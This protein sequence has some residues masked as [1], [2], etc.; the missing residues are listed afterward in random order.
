MK[1][2]ALLS[3]AS[4]LVVFA[5]TGVLAQ[6]VQ[7]AAPATASAP[8]STAGSDG[9]EPAAGRAAPTK[10]EQDIIVTGSRAASAGYQASTPTNVISGDVLTRQGA[11]NIS[12]VLNQD[13]AFK[14]VQ[15]PGANN[16]K[17]ATPGTATADLRGLG[18]Q[19]TLVLINGMRA[20]PVAPT[21]NTS[22]VATTDLNLIPSLMIDRVEVVTGGASAQWGSDAVAG[23]VNIQLRRKY[24]GLQIK[25]QAGISQYGDNADQRIGA[26][27]GFNFADDKGR[28]VAAVDY[29]N[30][31]GL[32]DIYT[33]DWGRRENQIISNPLR[34]TNGL[35]ALISAPNV[36]SAL[37]AGGLITGPA[38][39]AFRNFTFNP[40]STP[41]PFQLGSLVSGVQMIGGEGESVVKGLSLAPSVERVAS[42]GSLEY[43]LSDAITA[44]LEGSFGWSKGTLRGSLPRVTGLTIQRDNAYL[45]SSIRT[46]MLAAGIT[47]FG[48]QRNGFDIGNSNIQVSNKVPRFTGSLE[49]NLGG[50][51]SWDTNLT[52]GRDYY[53]QV[54]RNAPYAPNLRFALDAVVNPAS[55]QIVCRATIAGAAFNSGASGC[56]PLNFFG[57]GAP[58][59]ASLSYITPTTVS[60]SRY[61][62]QVAT[63]NLKGKPFSTWAGP[64]SIA[65]GFEYRHEKQVVKVDSFGASGGYLGAGNATPFAGSFNIKE[66]YLDTIVPLARD[67]SFAKSIDLNAAIR[68]ADYSTVGNQTTW[69]V[70]LTYAPFDLIRFR[71]TKSKDVRAPAI[72]EL[73]G[74]G[75][76]LTN[77]AT[78]RGQTA[79]IP[80]N[81]TLG[82][83]N[84]DAE[85]AKTFT[86][87]IVLQ[88]GG[89]FHASFD[90]YNIR[91]KGAIAS[92]SAANIGTFCDGGNQQFCNFYT[93]NAAGAPTSLFG[94]VLNIGSFQTKGIDGSVDYST[95]LGSLF[96][97]KESRFTVN[98]RGT[99]VFHA[100]VNS[101]TGVVIDR[102]GENT[103]QNLG[104]SPRFRGNLT[105]T[106]K[107][108]KVSFSL[109][110]IYVSKGKVDKLF[111]TLPTNT[112]ND[113]NIPAAMY[114]NAYTTI[115]VMDDFQVFIAVDNVIDK[116]P[117]LSP[118]PNLPVPP[119][120]GQYYDKVGRAFRAG[121]TAKF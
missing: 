56:A 107:V 19:R 70:G 53:R 120:N 68:Y 77:T 44:R 110:Q 46:A 22:V 114:L 64:V 87:G 36:H 83:P 65:T 76:L 88:P 119:V 47:N 3:S 32:G 25:A 31:H 57:N 72:Y 49:G 35:T 60:T 84:L 7:P 30:Y 89:G 15:N 45:P 71:V 81:T 90:Y 105:E 75:Q 55:G 103:E 67:L 66:V 112:I 79:N 117:P 37:G 8:T 61:N 121:I 52:V 95:D 62:Q 28:F 17:T 41:R 93:F 21:T 24:Q 100:L 109:Q 85:K 108:D 63:A 16:V 118:Y 33:R 11:T 4:A 2:R 82:N 5:P 111:N 78:V 12:Q 96:G 51:W 26:L 1:L 20:V 104:A 97:T 106:I 14:P 38:N 99:Y 50:G 98:A 94:T 91:V 13:P 54:I 6:G 59:A 23:V 27:G 29:D 42:Y 58:S 74:G 115:D 40:D 39:F 101:G 73:A 48:F 43:D 9:S 86:A 92:L 34:T 102:A 10:F 18:G 116:D 69:K 113:N 80:Q